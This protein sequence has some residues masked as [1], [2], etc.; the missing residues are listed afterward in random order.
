MNSNGKR[1]WFP[2]KRYGWGWGL[3]VAW[4]GW[5][6]L[7]LLAIGILATAWLV[8]PQRSPLAYGTCVVVWVALLIAVCLL[9]G[10]KPRW[11]WGDDE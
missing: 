3:P 4:Q 9:K 7:L 10:E 6:V 8:P 11:R 5:V 2:A 1:I